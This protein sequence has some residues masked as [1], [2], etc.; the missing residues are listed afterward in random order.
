M[1]SQQFISRKVMDG[2][3]LYRVHDI[4]NGVLANIR[5]IKQYDD[6]YQ[7]VLQLNKEDAE[8]IHSEG[9]IQVYDGPE[10]EKVFKA[11]TKHEEDVERHIVNIMTSTANTNAKTLD[12]R[13][14]AGHLFVISE[15][16]LVNN[17]PL[18]EYT[19]GE[20]DG[21]IVYY[22]PVLQQHDI[23][24]IIGNLL[25]DPFVGQNGMKEQFFQI[26]PNEYIGIIAHNNMYISVPLFLV[27]GNDGKLEWASSIDYLRYYNVSNGEVEFIPKPEDTFKTEEEGNQFLKKVIGDI[28]NRELG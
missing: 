1:Q 15:M 22:G 4:I 14:V 18:I 16:E 24:F 26:S 7:V 2:Y 5:A 20:S 8:F 23:E 21:R 25:E 28:S 13:N 27:E 11:L 3:K 19:Y 12:V 6:N 9:D 10:V 17:V